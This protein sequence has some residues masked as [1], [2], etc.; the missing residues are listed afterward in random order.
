MVIF[1]MKHKKQ[2]YLSASELLLCH[3]TAAGLQ[4]AGVDHLHPGAGLAAARAQ[5][6]DRLDDVEALL[7]VHPAKDDMLVVQPLCLD[8]GDEELRSVGV[9]A[10]V[11][12]GEQPRGAVL[13]QEVLITTVKTEWLD[14][15]HVVFGRG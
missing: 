5:G 4:H 2:V 11:G 14:N 15:K 7:I 6:L 3:A 13:H 10:G 8:G 12:H 9:G 1:S